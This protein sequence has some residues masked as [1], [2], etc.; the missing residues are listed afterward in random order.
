MVPECESNDKIF[1]CCHA[2]L[3]THYYICD[4]I[5]SLCRICFA[6]PPYI[7]VSPCNS[8]HVAQIIAQFACES[9]IRGQSRNSL[10]RTM[11]LC[12]VT[13]VALCGSGLEN[14]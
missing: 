9:R 13:V 3:L 4:R 12:M 5:M 6:S 11:F 14:I 7:I 2:T 8:F 10:K 1:C